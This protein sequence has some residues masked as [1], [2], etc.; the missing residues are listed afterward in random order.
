M[1]IGDIKNINKTICEIG[2]VW[3]EENGNGLVTKSQ[4][5]KSDIFVT[6][7]MGN[8]SEYILI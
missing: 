1:I 7:P 2:Q 3:H 5:G 6:N 8:L 4:N